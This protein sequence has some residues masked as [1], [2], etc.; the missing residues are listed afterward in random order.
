MLY[1]RCPIV[2]DKLRRNNVGIMLNKQYDLQAWKY[3]SHRKER[4]LRDCPHISSFP[5]YYVAIIFLYQ[6]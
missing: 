2:I 3:S 5:K 1:V 6:L 4:T